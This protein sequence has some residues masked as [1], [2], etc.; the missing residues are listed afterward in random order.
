MKSAK[1]LPASLLPASLL[2]TS[3]LLIFLPP[4]FKPLV[5]LLPFIFKKLNNYYT[6]AS[7]KGRLIKLLYK[8]FSIK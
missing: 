5:F 4:A 2:P 3:L 7:L 6:F 8:I 1:N